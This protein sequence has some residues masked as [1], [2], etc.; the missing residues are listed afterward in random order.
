MAEFKGDWERPATSS[1]KLGPTLSEQPIIFV[2]AYTTY[3]CRVQSLINQ[4]ANPGPPSSLI[5]SLCQQFPW[6]SNNN[7]Y[8]SSCLM[9]K[10]LRCVD[11]AWLIRKSNKKMTTAIK[12]ANTITSLACTAGLRFKLCC[13]G[14]EKRTGRPGAAKGFVVI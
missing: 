5:L 6:S 2:K 1:L 10:L 14:R 12:S 11:L 13:A 3:Y 8:M 4:L 7:L 9:V